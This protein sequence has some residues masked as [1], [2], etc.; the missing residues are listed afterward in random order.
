[1]ISPAKIAE[2]V[3]AGQDLALG[4]RNGAELRFRPAVERRQLVDIAL[5]A[6]GQRRFIFRVGFHQTIEDILRIQC[7]VRCAVPGVGIGH[8]FTL[9]I[10][11]MGLDAF[12]CHH[13]LALK[14]RGLNQAIQPPFQPQAVNHHHVGL[15]EQRAILR[16]R[17]EGVRIAVRADQGIHMDMLP[18]DLLRYITQHRKTAYHIQRFRHGPLRHQAEGQRDHYC[19]TFHHFLTPSMC[20]NR[21]A[22]GCA[23][24]K[25]AKQKTVRW[26][27]AQ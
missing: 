2:S 27:S 15:A 24:Q 13:Q 20:A 6:A 21:P 17:F 23:C 12:R 4:Q 3:M 5:A 22:A 16:R 26:R 14:T 9:F 19:T 1:M 25:I 7:A 10:K 8:R 11:G 18:A